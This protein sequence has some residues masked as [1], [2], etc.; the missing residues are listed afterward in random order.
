[1]RE[2][3]K[4]PHSNASGGRV[5]IMHDGAAD[6]TPPPEDNNRWATVGELLNRVMEYGTETV[7]WSIAVREGKGRAVSEVHHDRAIQAYRA[8]M[9]AAYRLGE[10]RGHNG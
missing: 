6:S 1:M 8:V 3:S 10:G 4:H 5:S 2:H 9:D 7:A